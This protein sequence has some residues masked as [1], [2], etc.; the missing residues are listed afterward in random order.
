MRLYARCRFLSPDHR[1]GTRRG[2]GGIGASSDHLEAI[3]EQNRDRSDSRNMDQE[4]KSNGTVTWNERE[5]RKRVPADSKVVL[6]LLGAMSIN[7]IMINALTHREDRLRNP[8][9]RVGHKFRRWHSGIWHDRPKIRHNPRI[10]LPQTAWDA[11][12]GQREG[13]NEGSHYCSVIRRLGPGTLDNIEAGFITRWTNNRTADSDRR[14]ADLITR[15]T[16]D[17][18]AD[19]IAGKPTSSH[20]EPITGP[21]IRIAGKPTSSHGEPMTGPGF[22]WR[23]VQIRVRHPRLLYDT[24]RNEAHREHESDPK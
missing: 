22:G 4:S 13:Q 10:R 1:N 6:P 18:T 2:S 23:A 21:G 8:D 5:A 12:D 15:W 3:V 19:S 7:Q 9:S 17:R 20:G 24:A 11:F 14:K 16:N